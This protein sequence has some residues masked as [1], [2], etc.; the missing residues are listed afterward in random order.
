MSRLTNSYRSCKDLQLFCFFLR[1]YQLILYDVI[2][3]LQSL[4]I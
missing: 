3:C 4:N 1:L 2:R